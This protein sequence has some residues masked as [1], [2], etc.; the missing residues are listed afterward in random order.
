MT[1]MHYRA[2]A[3]DGDGTLTTWG[4]MAAATRRALERLRDS[5]RKLLL[6]TGETAD[7]IGDFHHIELFDLVVG[8]D[9]GILYWPATGRIQT[10]AN[11]PPARLVRALK[12]CGVGSLRVG[13]VMLIARRKHTSTFRDVIA[14]LGLDY[15]LAFNGNQVLAAPRGVD[16]RSGLRAAARALGLTPRQ[17]VAVGDG[18]NDGPL[19]AG[20]GFGVAV[21]NAV[22]GLEERADRVTTGRRGKGVREV[23][24]QLLTD[25]LRS[26]ARPRQ[27]AR[28][29]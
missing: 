13:R 22:T 15:A 5:G 6:V 29:R 16:K 27:P 1:S 7:E 10:L 28:A 4:L 20:C 25:D 24:K 17:V 21:A 3:C 9:G 12:A 14:E 11:K 23:V 26:W 19:L 8:E 2:L 18:E